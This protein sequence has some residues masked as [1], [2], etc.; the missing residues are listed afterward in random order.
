[1]RLD[2]DKLFE[3]FKEKEILA[4]YHANTVGTSNTFFESRGL[5]SRGAVENL[6]LHQTPQA[7]DNI[8]KNLGVWNDVFLDTCDL[9]SF[10]GRENKYGPVL[11]ELD[12][13][14]IRNGEF[15]IWITKNNP[16][17]WN[18]NTTTQDR[19]FQ[20]V[21]ELRDKWCLIERHRKMVTIRNNRTPILFDYVR[22]IIVDDPKV[23]INEID[24]S[25]TH[26]F[27][28]VFH[29][30]RK[31]I[32]N[33]H[34]LKGKFIFRNCGTCWCTDNYLNQKTPNDLKRLFL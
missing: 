14:L 23:T 24:G 29:K 1:M 10:F 7:S 32:S 17:Y 18:K 30:I 27:N 12:R 33:D 19:Y 9:H 28:E 3:F 15:E 21:E 2:N 31:T 16:I 4:L 22:R 6:N 34:P 13:E 26:L 11:F 25:Q 20:S 5:L 8:D